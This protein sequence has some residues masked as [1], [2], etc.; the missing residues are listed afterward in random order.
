MQKTMERKITLILTTSASGC[1]CKGAGEEGYSRS[2]AGHLLL[3]TNQ[4]EGPRLPRTVVGERRGV[5][6]KWTPPPGQLF[7]GKRQCRRSSKFH[8]HTSSPQNTHPEWR[9]A[10]TQQR[11]LMSPLNDMHVRSD[12]CPTLRRP[13]DQ[14]GTAHQER[15][16]EGS[17]SLLSQRA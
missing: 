14:A 7:P 9:A 12:S 2:G 13:E 1:P 6:L 11:Q 3:T 15:H 17:V 8:L 16:G 4:S 10:A 5:S